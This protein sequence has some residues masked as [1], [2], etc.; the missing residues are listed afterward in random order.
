MDFTLTA[1]EQATVRQVA[2]HLRAGAPPT[3]DDLADE[4]GDETRPLLQSLLDKGWL[5]VGEDR[6]V[7]LSTIARAVLWEPSDQGDAGQPHR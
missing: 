6:T 2:A 3:D 7:T 4:L 5:V 1:A